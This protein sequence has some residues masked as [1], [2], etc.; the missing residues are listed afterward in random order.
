MET[1]L[2][3]RAG[4]FGMGLDTDFLTRR[5]MRTVIR[6]NKSSWTEVASGVPCGSVLAPIMFAK[7]IYIYIHMYVCIRGKKLYECVC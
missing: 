5:E 6:Y 2:C 3:W 4:R 1:K 7:Y